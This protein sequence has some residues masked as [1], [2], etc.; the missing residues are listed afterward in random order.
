VNGFELSLGHSITFI[1][2]QGDG[3]SPSSWERL[4]ADGDPDRAIW[5]P[6]I[7]ARKGLPGSFEL[8]MELGVV[9]LSSQSIVGGH[10]RWAPVEGYQRL[11]DVVLQ[12]GYT[13]YTGNDELEL[14]VMDLGASIGYSLAFGSVV[15]INTARFSPYAGATRLTLHAAPGLSDAE[16]IALNLAP[17]SGFRTSDYYDPDLNL[18]QLHGGFHLQSGGFSFEFSATYAMG[19]AASVNAGL[20]LVF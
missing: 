2:S 3:T 9:G 7:E 19:V 15:G 12:G 6:R 16:M 18:W 1:D 14:G 8:A 10:L 4:H 17:I 5:I 11:P 13:G 20:G